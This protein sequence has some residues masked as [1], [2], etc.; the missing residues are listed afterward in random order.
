MTGQT[1][2]PARRN[3]LRWLLIASLAL[4]LLIGGAVAARFFM[5]E[6]MERMMG[7][8]NATQLL[9]RRFLHD[10]PRERRRQLLDVLKAHGEAFRAARTEMR[11][12]TAQL[13]AALE[14]DP[15]VA[16]DAES[17]IM[18]F[19]SAGGGVIKTGEAAAREVL[20]ML[21]PEERKM[22]AKR[23]RERPGRRRRN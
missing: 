8:N 10:L 3:W 1:S 2:S 23:L 14:A 5:P 16:A 19:S 20:A 7:L 6:R 22:L 9:P 4:N 17:A 18:A 12:A 15:Y 11:A 13:A 21:T